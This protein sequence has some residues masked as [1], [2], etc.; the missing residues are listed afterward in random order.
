MKAKAVTTAKLTPEEYT[1]LFLKKVPRNVDPKT[2]EKYK[3]LHTVFS[4][5][6]TAFEQMFGIKPDELTR[7]SKNKDN[8]PAGS[9]V[10]SGQIASRFVKGGV[11]IYLP[12]D[13][14]STS[15]ATSAS[16]AA[17]NKMLMASL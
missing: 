11:M 3:G 7:P 5:Y 9:M 4:G 8:K 6:N 17:I 12:E 15:A 16:A 14:P 10:A 13:A 1:L 2:G